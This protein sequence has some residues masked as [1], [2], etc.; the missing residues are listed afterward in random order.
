MLTLNRTCLEYWINVEDTA[1][2]HVAALTRPDIEGSRIFGFTGRFNW[3]TLLH[4][5]R[6]MYP[7]RTFYDDRE[8]LGH[9]LSRIHG[10][11]KAEQILKDMGRPGWKGLEESMR[12]NLEDLRW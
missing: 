9:D 6:K 11:A 7:D 4:Q 3:N 2:L 12:E 10:A 8:G 5:L 1:R